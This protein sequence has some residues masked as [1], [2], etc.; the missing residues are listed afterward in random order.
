MV[1]LSPTATGVI[2]YAHTP[3]LPASARQNSGSAPLTSGCVVPPAHVTKISVG[4]AVSVVSQHPPASR[5]QAQLVS[6]VAEA[7]TETAAWA[8]PDPAIRATPAAARQADER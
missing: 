2:E 6:T 1:T 4:N 5:A 7:E 3:P 8:T